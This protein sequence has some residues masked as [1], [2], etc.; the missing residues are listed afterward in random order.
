M[1][2]DR[3]ENIVACRACCDSAVLLL[4]CAYESFMKGAKDGLKTSLGVFPVMTLLIVS[5]SMFSAS[6]A[7]EM[8]SSFL[9]P[10]CSRLGVPEGIIPLVVMRPFS[11]SASTA[12]YSALLDKFGADSFESFAASVIMGSGDTLVYVIS[13]YYSQSKK[14]RICLSGVGV[15]RAV[16]CFFRLYTRATIYE[17]IL[18]SV[19]TLPYR[20]QE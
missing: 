10:V 12:A 2:H 18:P 11:G 14:E 7:A 16:C 6:G 4:P 5:L 15:C 8:I 19:H 17:L 9:S 1:A 20:R 13:V 3:G